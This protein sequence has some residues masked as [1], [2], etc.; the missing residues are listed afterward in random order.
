[1]LSR[2]ADSIY[3]MSRYIERAE[4]VARFIDVNLHRLLD[5]PVV[6]DEQW[7]PLVITTGDHAQFLARYGKATRETVIRFLTFDGE[8]PNSILS[9]LRASRENARTVRE[10]ISRE[11]WEQVNKFY[12][13]VTAAAAS[14]RAM[15]S[16]H[17]FFSDVR[18]ASQL[19]AGVT[20]ATMSRNEG[21]HFR[22]LGELLERA[23]QTTRILDVKCFFLLASEVRG[24]GA[25]DDIQWSAVL[26]SAS[27]FEMYR[28]RHGPLSPRC[29]VEFL[30]LD[31]EFPRATQFC[32]MGAERSLHAVTGTTLGTFRNVAEQRLGQL[33]SELAYASLEDIF[34]AGLHEFLDGLQVRLNLVGD[35]IFDTFFALRPLQKVAAGPRGSFP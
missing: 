11:M 19:F 30:L 24:E 22:Q 9:C 10:V 8:N 2:V 14:E 21:W 27:A 29:I 16:P 17:D 6:A 18:L 1:M 32:L 3:W 28:Q 34:R 35:A 4:S 13:M 20:D 5:L 26:R 7:E 23:D 12:L 15:I 31:R 25:H 33:R